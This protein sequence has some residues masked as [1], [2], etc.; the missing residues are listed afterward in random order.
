MTFRFPG[1][2]R[3]QSDGLAFQRA[4]L[5]RLR[6]ANLVCR[7]I[8]RHSPWSVLGGLLLHRSFDRHSKLVLWAGGWPMPAIQNQGLLQTEGCTLWAGVRLEVGV[9][10]SLSIGKGTYLNR[11]TTVVCH[12]R[13]TIGP[14]CMIAWD[15]NI[16][17]TDQHG[18]DQTRLTAPVNIGEGV[19]IGCRAIILKGVTIGNGAVIGAGSVVTRDVPPFTVAVGHPA[20][21]IRHLRG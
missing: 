8:R 20:R 12:D 19:W 15:V 3:F 17:D 9:S 6:A 11:R 10:A 2:A 4:L 13:I 21:V 14:N 16:M 7:R 5:F 1:R 18:R